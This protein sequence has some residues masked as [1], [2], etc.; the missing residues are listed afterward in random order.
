MNCKNVAATVTVCMIFNRELLLA[1]WCL[2]FIALFLQAMYCKIV[3]KVW[4]YAT[5]ALVSEPTAQLA[6]QAAW[7]PRAQAQQGGPFS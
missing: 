2:V 5:L 7:S 3:V 6:W 1:S 4:L